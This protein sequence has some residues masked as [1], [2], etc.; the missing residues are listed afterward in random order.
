MV[1]GA[2]LRLSVRYT[3]R[4]D[5]STHLKSHTSGTLTPGAGSCPDPRAT[6]RISLRIHHHLSG[7]GLI[8]AYRFGRMPMMDTPLM[9]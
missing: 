6:S 8:P 1:A 5:A 7:Q 2:D 9:G 4:M 3:V